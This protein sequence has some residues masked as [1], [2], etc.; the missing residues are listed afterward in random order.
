MI[1]EPD[2]KIS[3]P[4]QLVLTNSQVVTLR[5][6]FATKSSTDIKLSKTQ[7]SKKIQCRRISW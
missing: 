5:T 6:T 1:G 2:E 3:F 7:T 4:H